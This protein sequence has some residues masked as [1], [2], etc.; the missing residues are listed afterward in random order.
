VAPAWAW[1][2][3]PWPGSRLSGREVYLAEPKALGADQ[4]VCDVSFLLADQ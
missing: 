4:A 1:P 2:L 3:R